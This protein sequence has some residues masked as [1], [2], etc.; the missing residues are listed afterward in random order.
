MQSESLPRDAYA[1]SRWVGA[2]APA[3]HSGTGSP[4]SRQGRTDSG[5][6]G[7]IC[8]LITTCLPVEAWLENIL[9]QNSWKHPNCAPEGYWQKEN[10]DRPN[11]A[12]LHSY[13]SRGTPSSLK[14][15]SKIFAFQ[16][17]V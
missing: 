8:L 15:S 13:E 9:E 12:G 14:S 4:V 7:I 5:Q 3:W 11:N 16:F 2:H 17:L 6:A 1:V 10:A